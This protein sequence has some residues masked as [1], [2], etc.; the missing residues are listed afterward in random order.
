MGRT[1][2]EAQAQ[3]LWPLN[4]KQDSLE[5]IQGWEKEKQKG[6][7]M[8]GGEDVNLG[9][10]WETMEDRGGGMLWSMKL[11]RDGHD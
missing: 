7:G 5:K 2:P 6:E 3:I 9:K 10:F 8:A 11:Q 1:D 4:D